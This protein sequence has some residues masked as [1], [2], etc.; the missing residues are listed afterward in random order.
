MLNENNYMC[1]LIVCYN[2][3]LIY[4]I[5]IDLYNTP[6]NC[7]LA[8]SCTY[9]LI[10]ESHKRT[11]YTI[12]FISRPHMFNV[13]NMSC[14]VFVVMITVGDGGEEGIQRSPKDPD[15]D[16]ARIARVCVVLSCM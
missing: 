15:A 2:T 13:V 12:S 16:L 9:L 10:L 8:W 14:H 11:K 5:V 6:C 7:S 3:C 1:A 4:V